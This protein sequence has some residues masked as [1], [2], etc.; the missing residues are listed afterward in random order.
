MF[1][2]EIIV[3]SIKTCFDYNVIYLYGFLFYSIFKFDLTQQ[4]KF[5]YQKNLKIPDILIKLNI[6][7]VLLHCN[8]I[9]SFIVPKLCYY[10][11]D[12]QF[13]ISKT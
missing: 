9:K 11:N 5:W 8:M 1:V 4:L 13:K 6:L 7:L 2:I 10:S 12:K 3:R